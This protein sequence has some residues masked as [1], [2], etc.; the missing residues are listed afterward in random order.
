MHLRGTF[1]M[2]CLTLLLGLASVAAAGPATP[3]G[4]GDPP[5]PLAADAAERDPVVHEASTAPSAAG[6]LLAQAE[7]EPDA[8]EQENQEE[9]PFADE[10][11]EEEK[12]APDEIPDPLYAWN[13]GWFWV[14][15]YFYTYAWEPLAKGYKF[16]TPDFFRT[17]VRNFF[18]NLFT[19]IRLVNCLLQGKW[20]SA[21]NEAARFMVNT[22]VGILGFRDPASEAYGPPKDEDLGQ[23]LGHWGWNDGFYL[24]WPILGPSSLR[25]TIG[26]VGDNFLNPLSYVDG[27]P[28]E[29][30]TLELGLKAYERLN[31]TTFYI[32]EYERLKSMALDP[33]I[34]IRNAYYQ[35][36]LKK[37]S[38]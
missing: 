9:D 32:G 31:T 30:S 3:T 8:A 1:W 28:T 4:L 21:G 12:A 25:D 5:R 36:R 20:E 29:T 18:T 22:T 7:A 17:G 24:V 38:E 2:T 14:N 16:I 26:L 35:N 37:I 27:T 15:D 11:D 19:P 23:T 34:A 6:Q 33:Y 13:W 10:W